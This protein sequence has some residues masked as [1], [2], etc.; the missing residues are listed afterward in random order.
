MLKIGLVDCDT[1]HVVAFTQRLNH[2][3]IDPSLWV[4]GA[5]VVAAVSLPSLV[6]P[7]RVPGFVEQLRGWNVAVLDKPEELIGQVDAVMVTSVDGSIHLER[8]R[9]FLEARLPLFVDKPFATS[10]DDARRIVD[11]AQARGVAVTSASALRYAPEVLAVHARSSELGAIVG[12]DAFTP[13]VLHP[14]NPGLFHYG[15]HGVETV[16]ALMGAGC[17]AVRCVY[18]DG[19]EVVVGRWADG[20]LGTV[21]A[22]RLGSYALG[23]TCFAERGVAPA[24]VDSRTL[25]TDMLRVALEMFR[26]GAWPLS[27]TELLEPVAFMEAALRSKEQ[28]GAEVELPAL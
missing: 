1:S 3:G 11:M 7:E 2:V 25:Y 13:G 4:E 15:V 18:Q 24:L 28:G 23:F 22:N 27:P 16:Y 14:R 12:V 17:R 26:T 5:T 9:P 8:A 21:R 20:R 10:L 6:S 19:G